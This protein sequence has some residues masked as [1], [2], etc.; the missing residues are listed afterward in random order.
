MTG[1]YCLPLCDDVALG[2]EGLCDEAV[3]DAEGLEKDAAGL[4]ALVLPEFVL[5][6]RHQ[7]RRQLDRQRRQEGE[8]A[9][10]AERGA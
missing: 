9:K 4:D 3:G 8:A 2:L 7:R 5:I 10:G 6:R 1:H